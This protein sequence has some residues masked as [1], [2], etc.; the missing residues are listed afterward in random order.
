MPELFR[1]S[2]RVTVGSK[3]FGS[4]NE[5]R[6]LRFAFSVERDHT[7]VPNN[8][9]VT[10]WGLNDD[11]RAELEERSAT[12]GGVPVRVEVGYGTDL[13]QIFLG[14]LRRVASWRDAPGWVTEVSGGDGEHEIVTAKVSQ[15]FKAGTPVSSVLAALV[16]ALGTGVGNLSSLSAT[17]FDAGGTTLQKDL[18]MRGD[19]AQALEQFC[20][21]LGIRWSIQDGVFFAAKVGD[22]FAPGK[23]PLLTPG[24]G[25]LE[26][27]G[28]DKDGK[29]SGLCLMNTDLLPGRVFRVESDRITGNFVAEQTHHFG[30]SSGQEWYTEFVGTPPAKGSKAASA[31]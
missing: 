25:L 9:S 28:V 29:V 6:P 27:P 13:G 15:T 3:Q 7:K 2:F 30:E 14:G 10:L 31:R 4:A 17:G 22:A 5:L 8:A 18:A 11:T 16:K 1:R 21:S 19:A 20:R 26:T 23:G 24:T 12:P